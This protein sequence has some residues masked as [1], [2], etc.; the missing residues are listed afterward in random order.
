MDGRPDQA[1][2]FI[3]CGVVGCGRHVSQREIQEA[4]EKAYNTK[5]G[6][7]GSA[8]APKWPEV[9]FDLVE[10]IVAS[11]NGFG[12]ANLQELSPVQFADNLPHSDQVVET[13]LGCDDETLVC[14]GWAKDRFTT[15]SFAALKDQLPQVQF[16]VPSPMSAR[17]W[18]KPDG[19]LSEKGNA[20]T[21]PRRNLVVEFDMSKLDK[22]GKPTKWAPLIE[23]WDAQ[24]ITP[25]D[26][27]AALI[28]H[29]KEKGS[30]MCVV[31]SAGK[32]L[33]AWFRCA[34][35]AP[36]ET[37]SLLRK[38]FEYAAA[39]GGDSAM[40]TRSQFVRMPDGM[41]DGKRQAVLYFDPNGAETTREAKKNFNDEGRENMKN[42]NGDGSGS[43]SEI[44]RKLLWEEIQIRNKSLPIEKRI[45]EERFKELEALAILQ[46]GPPRSGQGR[47]WS[48]RRSR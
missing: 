10:K 12:L 40:W 39:M 42:D 19:Q 2:D 15:D 29:L 3:A 25:K 48:E 41:R 8:P 14:I 36:E 23:N 20:N 43:D 17:T 9:N 37:G 24:G 7:N 27:M 6:G 35:D 30:L 26:A 16:I 46:D 38:F 11:A 45:T 5:V 13:L 28:W 34:I 18:T 47:S 1:P 44:E 31:D 33:H 21:G 22:A 4:V 32:S